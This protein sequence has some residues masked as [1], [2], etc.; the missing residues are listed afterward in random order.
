MGE[1]E[2]TKNRGRMVGDGK[3]LSAFDDFDLCV[4]ETI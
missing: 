4:G 1:D 2:K 3:V